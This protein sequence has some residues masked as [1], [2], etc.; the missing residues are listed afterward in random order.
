M[1]ESYDSSAAEA[2]KI[3]LVAIVRASYSYVFAQKALLPAVL[4][5]PVVLYY[6]LSAVAGFVSGSHEASAPH[7]RVFAL[8]VFGVV[9]LCPAALLF[10]TWHR[11]ILLGNDGGQPAWFYPLRGRHWKYAAFMLAAATAGFLSTIFNAFAFVFVTA[12]LTSISSVFG[13]ISILFFFFGLPAIYI[14]LFAKLSF[15]FPAIAVDERYRIADA[16]RQTDGVLWPLS[17]GFL[18][19]FL[20]GCVLVIAMSFG[21]FDIVREFGHVPFWLEAANLFLLSYF[22]LVAA[23]FITFVFQYKTGW[24]PAVPDDR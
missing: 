11:L 17:A 20:P 22:G 16:W 3:P 21:L 14:G 2:R 18:M 9:L 13:K 4:L 5:Q 24:I 1:S 15:L 8:D 19:C 10:V 12:F 7:E 23:T 6:A